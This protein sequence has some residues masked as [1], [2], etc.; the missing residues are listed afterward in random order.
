VE[1]EAALTEDVAVHVRAMR[2]FLDTA[3]RGIVR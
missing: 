1:Q 2:T 3:H